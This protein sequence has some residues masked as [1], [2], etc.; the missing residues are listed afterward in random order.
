MDTI[1]EFYKVNSMRGPYNGLIRNPCKGLEGY[2]QWVTRCGG[3]V[4]RDAATDIPAAGIGG[5]P[6]PGRQT[7]ITHIKLKFPRHAASQS[8]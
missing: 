3:D 6:R 4:V 2:R 1:V 5:C 8:G 7:G